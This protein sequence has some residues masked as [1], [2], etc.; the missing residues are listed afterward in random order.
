VLA[1]VPSVAVSGI[2]AYVDADKRPAIA[3]LVVGGAA[4]LFFNVLPFALAVC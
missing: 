3:G 2:G 4:T 1:P